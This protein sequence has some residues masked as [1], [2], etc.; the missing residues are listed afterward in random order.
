MDLPSQTL[1]WICPAVKS[2][3]Y[4]ASL[5]QYD[6]ACLGFLIGPKGDRNQPRFEFAL[7]GVLMQTRDGVDYAERFIEMESLVPPARYFTEKIDRELLGVWAA[8]DDIDTTTNARV[9]ALFNLALSVEVPWVLEA[10]TSGGEAILAPRVFSVQEFPRK[11]LPYK[12]TKRS[13]SGPNDNPRRIAAMWK[14]AR[15]V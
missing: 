13:I 8:W 5:A 15:E 1:I 3:I 14:R 7:I 10:R 11:P 12:L 2:A 4:R 9:D 6:R